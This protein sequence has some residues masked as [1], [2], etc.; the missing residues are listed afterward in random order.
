MFDSIFVQVVDAGQKYCGRT[1]SQPICVIMASNKE[2]VASFHTVLEGTT[3][4]MYSQST[5]GP[6]LF[7]FLGKISQIP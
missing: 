1:F 6:D 7:F 5:R 2:L 4:G 3:V